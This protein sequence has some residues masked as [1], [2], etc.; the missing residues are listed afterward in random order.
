MEGREKH[1]YPRNKEYIYC[2]KNGMIY[3]NMGSSVQILHFNA[4]HVNCFMS[5]SEEIALT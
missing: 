5:H 3:M 1:S 2:E 4:S